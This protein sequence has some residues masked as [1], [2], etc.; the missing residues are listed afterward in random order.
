METTD[1]KKALDN[2]PGAAID[3]ADSDKVSE[4]AVLQETRDLNNNP[5]END[6]QMP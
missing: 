3:R 2:Y 6:D 4:K 1:P 5:R